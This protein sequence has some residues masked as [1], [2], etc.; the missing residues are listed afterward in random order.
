MKSTNQIHRQNIKD[1][2]PFKQWIT[3]E[4]A[5]YIS[6]FPDKKF[7]EDDF[8]LW[9]NRKYN[10]HPNWWQTIKKDHF[11]YATPDV[12][13]TSTAPTNGQNSISWYEKNKDVISQWLTN[14]GI[15]IGN[16]NT[17]ATTDVVTTEKDGFRIMGM[18]GFVALALGISIVG[19]TIYGFNYYSKNS[20]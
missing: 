1:N 4:K 18:N 6:S 3:V 13:G 10:L 5:T 19:L 15:L 16:S 9:L 7:S 14:A 12:N 20:K 11:N 8:V 2:T 17:P